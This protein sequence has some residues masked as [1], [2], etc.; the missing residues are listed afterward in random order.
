VTDNGFEVGLVLHRQAFSRLQYHDVVQDVFYQLHGEALI[1]V[2]ADSRP[3]ERFLPGKLLGKV[4]GLL[5]A[6]WLGS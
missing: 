2:N 6:G 3:A 1:G 4:A 5:I